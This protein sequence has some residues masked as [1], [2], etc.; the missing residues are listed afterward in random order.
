MPR[1]CLFLAAVS[2]ALASVTGS[3]SADTFR[4][5]AK[6]GKYTSTLVGS[7][8]GQ[9]IQVYAAK[10]C[11]TKK[12]H[13]WS[14][15]FSRSKA[16]LPRSGSFELIA[17]KKIVGAHNRKLERATVRVTGRRT[18]TLLTGTISSTGVCEFSGTFRTKL[19]DDGPTHTTPT[20][21][22]QPT[23]TPPPPV[24]PGENDKWNAT[25][26]WCSFQYRCESAEVLPH[27]C[28]G[29]HSDCSPDRCTSAGKDFAYWHDLMIA[30]RDALIQAALTNDP[31]G[32][33]LADAMIDVGAAGQPISQFNLLMYCGSDRFAALQRV[34]SSGFTWSFSYPG[35]T[36]PLADALAMLDTALKLAAVQPD[37]TGPLP[38]SVTVQGPDGWTLELSPGVSGYDATFSHDG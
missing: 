38:N 9:T 12:S 2:I 15:A 5:T 14:V 17:H 27:D 13:G 11:A 8:I 20:P 21:T 33:A 35:V 23:P 16:K 18:K 26:L 10:V 6:D 32:R 37:V 4:P 28:P 19:A 3:A 30:G 25:G 36:P 24:T 29:L 31:L 34:D 7:R 22:P 1:I